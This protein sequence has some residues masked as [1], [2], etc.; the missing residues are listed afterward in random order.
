MN[1]TMFFAL[2]AALFATACT[3][4]VG[5][6]GNGNCTAS[7][8]SS[9]PSTPPSYQTDVAPLLQTYCVSCHSAGGSESGKPLDTYRGVA[10]LSGGVE[11]SVG[12]CSMPP[13]NEA[14]PTDAE[15]ETILAWLVCGANQ[16]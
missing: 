16:N 7:V 9:C 4:Q 13:A 3:S 10:N 12:S 6:T 14:Q 2:F 1:R 8:P 15:R 5:G 11:S